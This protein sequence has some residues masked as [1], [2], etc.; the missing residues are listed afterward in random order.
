MT[1]LPGGNAVVRSMV[2][3]GA[4]L[5]LAYLTTRP[6]ATLLSF[7]GTPIGW[8]GV[9]VLIIGVGLHLWSNV[10]LARLEGGSSESAPTALVT[11]GPYRYIRNPIYVAGGLILLGVYLCHAELRRMDIV[12]AVVLMSVLHV[13]VVRREE[14]ALR[15]RFGPTYEEYCRHVPRW[16]PSLIAPLRPRAEGP[17]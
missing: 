14:P 7:R 9:A 6:A 1:L 16:F 15:R 13:L 3:L 10:T 8:L 11:G 17:V 2:W 4:G 12:A 5:L